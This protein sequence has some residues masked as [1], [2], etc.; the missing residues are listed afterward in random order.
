[1]LV[2]APKH[3]QD[4][5]LAIGQHLLL[6]SSSTLA[7]LV[8]ALTVGLL[9]VDRPKLLAAAMFIANMIFVV[10]SL[11]MFALLIPLVGLGFTPVFISLTAYAFLI[12]LRNVEAGLRGT[13]SD[14]L[15]AA[16]GIGYN[17]YQRLLKVEFPL[18]LPMIVS[19]ARLAL[20]TSIG[21]ATVAALVGGGGLG[22]IILIGVNQEHSEKVLIGS[23]AT[24]VLAFLCD[25]ALTFLERLA[26]PW[27]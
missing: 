25:I 8:L 7:G 20:V 21:I 22:A 16:D 12:I 26:L 10:P 5:G 2:W 23:L 14:V 1:M 13:S 18:A 4:I 6:T 27:R 3:L 11:A 15:D 19:G 17:R 24:A 9:S